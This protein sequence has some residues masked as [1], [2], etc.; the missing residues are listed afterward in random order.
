MTARKMNGAWWVDFRFEHRRLRLKSPVDTKRGAEEYERGLRLRLLDGTFGKEEDENAKRAKTITVK[1]FAKEFLETYAVP[2]N[3]PSEVNSKTVSLRRHLVP[4]F[5]HLKLKQVEPK[6]IEKYKVQKLAEGLH[7]KSINNHLIVLHRMLAVAVE[8]G[9]LDHAPV[10]KKL[11]APAPEFDFL[12]FEEADKLV[13]AAEGEWRAMIVT[14]L[15]TGLR[16]GELL[17][18]RWEDVDLNIGKIVVR[19]SAYKGIF[20]TPKSGR[21]REISLSQEAVRT[22]K[23]HRHLRGELV[24]CSKKGRLLCMNACYKALDETTKRAGLRHMGWHV[25]RHTFASHLAMR[26][27]PIKAIQELLGHATIEMTMRYAHLSPVLHQDAVQRLDFRATA[28]GHQVGI[29]AGA[30]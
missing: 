8:W 6:L 18:L 9:L 22:L 28:S 2:N 3:K 4:F 12:D 13:E 24:F 7:P 20:G 29:D 15:K 26:G 16:F 21:A 11:K 25:L 1:E 23:G 27:V 5:G 30:Q 14:A 10:F 19:R 17:A